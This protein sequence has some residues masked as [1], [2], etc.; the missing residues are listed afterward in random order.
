MGKFL[1]EKNEIIVRDFHNVYVYANDI[2]YKLDVYLTNKRLVLLKEISNELDYVSVLKGRG[3]GFP[4]EYDTVFDVE[5]NEIDTVNYIDQ[6]NHV[7][8]KN[9]PNVLDIY[10]GDLTQFF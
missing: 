8:L 5:I 7:K 4:L 10:C 3:H 1:L 6:Y 2:E 9:S